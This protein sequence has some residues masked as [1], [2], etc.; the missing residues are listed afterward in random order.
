MSSILYEKAIEMEGD[1]LETIPVHRGRVQIT[2]DLLDELYCVPYDPFTIHVEVEFLFSLL[3]NR[4]RAEQ[5]VFAI[6]LGPARIA[7]L[8]AAKGYFSADGL[9]TL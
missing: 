5:L 3:A 1:R 9:T 6:P 2:V 7:K 8:I 4:P